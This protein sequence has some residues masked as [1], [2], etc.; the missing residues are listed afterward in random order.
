MSL[1]KGGPSTMSRRGGSWQ[2]YIPQIGVSPGCRSGAAGMQENQ[3]ISYIA[4]K[5]ENLNAHPRTELPRAAQSSL[6]ASCLKDPAPDNACEAATLKGNR[7]NESSFNGDLTISADESRRCRGPHHGRITDSSVT[8]G[9]NLVSKTFLAS[10]LRRQL[11]EVA[12]RPPDN[13]GAGM[14]PLVDIRDDLPV[15]KTI[16]KDANALKDERARSIDPESFSSSFRPN[17]LQSRSTIVQYTRVY[18]TQT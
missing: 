12:F 4:E 3:T 16:F 7:K 11:G 13:I 9:D 5:Y 6:I 17:P 8:L 1:K 15:K 18:G 10:P 2:P 14:Q